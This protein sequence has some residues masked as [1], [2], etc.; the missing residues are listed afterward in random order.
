MHCLLMQLR[1]LQHSDERL[2]VFSGFLQ[3]LQ[4]RELV[5][6]P[7]QVKAGVVKQHCARFAIGDV[8]VQDR[9]NRRLNNTIL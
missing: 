7:S 9:I 5:D 1:P 2:Q 3:T 8:V 4:M 6:A